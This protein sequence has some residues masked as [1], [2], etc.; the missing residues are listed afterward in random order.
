MST[1]PEFLEA[2]HP[3]NIKNGIGLLR[4][5]FLFQAASFYRENNP[6][7][8]SFFVK[9]MIQIGEKQVIKMYLT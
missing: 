1:K 6:T 8:S 9:E 3:N 4:M 7:I 5:N 2:T